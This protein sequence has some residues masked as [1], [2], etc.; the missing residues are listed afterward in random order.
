MAPSDGLSALKLGISSHDAVNLL[1]STGCNDS[2][3]ANQVLLN[4]SKRIA[5]LH[6]HTA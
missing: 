1:L 3:E 6:L 2:E 5:E 4:L